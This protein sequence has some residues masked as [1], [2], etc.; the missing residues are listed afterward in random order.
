MINQLNLQARKNTGV[1]PFSVNPGWHRSKTDPKLTCGKPE[2]TTLRMGDGRV[3]LRSVSSVS[4]SQCTAML[5]AH[6]L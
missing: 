5:K 3:I 2:M 4:Y 6:T 1:N